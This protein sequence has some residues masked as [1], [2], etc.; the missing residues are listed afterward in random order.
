LAKVF[1]PQ[2][3]K[4][5]LPP[6]ELPKEHIRRLEAEGE[7]SARERRALEGLQLEQ[8]R[9]RYQNAPQ[10]VTVPLL[11]DPA[12]PYAV[13]I[14]DPGSGKSTLL[15][16]LLLDWAED[17]VGRPL[18]LFVELRQCARESSDWKGDFCQYFAVAANPIFSFNATKLE[19][20]CALCRVGH[21][22]VGL[23]RARGDLK[24]A[25]CGRRMDPR[26]RTTDSIREIRFS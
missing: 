3:V 26:W 16:W 13:I 12:C 17:P 21:Y 15:E 9:Q 1:I 18:P 10:H 4:E 7:I 11:R 25:R 8:Y 6:I 20:G 22:D 24:R 14:G 2:N 19:A 5:D 23:I